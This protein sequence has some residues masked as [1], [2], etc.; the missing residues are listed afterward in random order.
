MLS[1][2]MLRVVNKPEGIHKAV[3]P[4]LKQRLVSNVSGS[5]IAGKVLLSDLHYN[6]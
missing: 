5:R 4:M 1:I 3:E 6:T 2:V